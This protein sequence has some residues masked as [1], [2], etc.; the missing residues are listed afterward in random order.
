MRATL[1]NHAC[2]LF[3]FDEFGLLTD[4]WLDGN[5]FG[6]SWRLIAATPEYLKDVLRRQTTHLYI[7]HEHSDHFHPPTLRYFYAAEA[8]QKPQVL[9]RETLD[10]RVNRWMLN[11]GFNVKSLTERKFAKQ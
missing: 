11:K 9:L 7:P 3:E 10:G 4:P 8:E 1:V 2:V 5:I 6:N